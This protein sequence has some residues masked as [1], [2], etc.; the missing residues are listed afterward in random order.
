MKL[1]HIALGFVLTW[2]LGVTGQNWFDAEILR[3]HVRVLASD[4]LEGRGTGTNGEKLAADYI[5]SNFKKYKL[6]PAGDNKTWLQEFSFKTSS[7]HGEGREGKAKNVIG[8][9]NN[10]APLTIVIGAH[11]DHL[12]RGGDGS[13]LDPNNTDNIHNGADDNAS[14]VAGLLEL[15]RYYATN[16]EKEPFN[17]LFIAFSGEE[18][19]LLGSDWFVNHPTIDLSKV[20]CMFNMDMIGRLN[21]DKPAL[22]INGVGTAPEWKSLAES[23]SSAVMQI[24][25]DS[26][27]IGPSD[28][29]SFYHKSIPA[30]HF[31]TGT[32]TD[33]H[34][35]SDDYEKINAPGMEAVLL[36][37]SGMIEK[38]PRE[39]MTFLKTRNASTTSRAKFSVSLGIMP[40]YANTGTGLKAEAV[41][42]GKPGRNAGM[43]DGDIVTAIGEYV[44]TDIQ[45]YMEALGKFKKG[46]KTIVKILR[47]EENLNLEVE[48]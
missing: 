32:H 38:L 6:S 23:F 9:L 36:V 22:T 48:F 11:Y 45:S 33:Y 2:S 46:D 4:S 31:F 20:T 37:M 34:K 10:K 5:I 12:G 19:G 24:T 15:A 21:R 7:H 1:K 13:S 26:S 41:L 18:L 17:F 16:G 29:S 42:E 3:K 25:T 28:H 8:Y 43:Q 44:I 27:G 47:G 14:G 39:K 40:S 30:L 35:P